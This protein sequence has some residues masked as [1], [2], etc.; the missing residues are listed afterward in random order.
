MSPGAVDLTRGAGYFSPQAYK[1]KM[2]KP[3]Y[4]SKTVDVVPG[5]NPW[6]FG[7]IMLGG[8]VGMVIVDP[9]T[10]AMFKLYPREIDGELEPTGEDIAAIEQ[11]EAFI[12][13]TRL[14]PTSRNDYIARQKAKELNCLP[15]GNPT[16]D[17]L[18]TA[19]ELI[20]FTCRDGRQLALQCQSGA[21]CRS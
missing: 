6:Y 19:R 4:I 10:G 17:G 18:N 5:M 16:V 13:K 15:I 2:S 20:T 7:N 1:V 8:F 3:G 21:G 12:Q 11:E 14:Y 9:L